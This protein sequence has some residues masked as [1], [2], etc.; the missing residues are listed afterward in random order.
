MFL[1]RDKG[2]LELD[3]LD[4]S[5]FGRVKEVERLRGILSGVGSG[6]LPKLTSVHG[7]PGS[8]KTFVVRKVCSEFEASSRGRFRFVYV[9]LGEVKTVFGFA[10][11]LLGVMGGRWRT[12]R[13]GLDGVLEEF[14]GKVLDWKGDGKKFLLV[15]MDEADRLFMD[16]RGDPSGLLYRLVRSQDRLRGSGVSLSLLTVSNLSFGEIWEL[17]GRVRSSMGFEEIFFQPYSRDELK[18][19]LMGRFA[20]AFNPGVVDEQVLEACLDYMTRQ[21][22]DVRRMLDLLRICGEM[23]EAEQSPKVEMKHFTQTRERLEQDHHKSLLGGLAGMQ[24]TV[25]YIL[26]RLLEF[27]HEVAPST[28]QLYQE[29]QE[30]A[31]KA[32]PSYRRVADI[33]KELEVMNLVGTSLVSKGRGGRSNEVWLEIPADVILDFVE[34]DWRQ[35]RDHIEEMKKKWIDAYGKPAGMG[36]LSA[37]ERRYRKQRGW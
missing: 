13:V 12:G 9:N 3:R 34:P 31:Q 29:Y 19:I 1:F 7:P 15:C 23:A 4:V 17:D 21:S 5:V 18:G 25:L 32:C 14:W 16:Q 22:M 11:R 8:G 6:F 20:E 28:S 24:L 30:R 36:R 10:N 26:A 33:L 37:E 27:D 35:L 2:A